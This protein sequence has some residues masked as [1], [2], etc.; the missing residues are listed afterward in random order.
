MS[1][2]HIQ[3]GREH[4]ELGLPRHKFQ[5]PYLQQQY[6]KGYDGDSGALK[7]MKKF[8]TDQQQKRDVFKD[9]YQ[10]LRKNGGLRDPFDD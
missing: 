3:L 4:A 1:Q 8:V 5:D 10:Q 2:D 9:R 6:D 7:A